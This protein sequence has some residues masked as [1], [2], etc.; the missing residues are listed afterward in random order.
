MAAGAVDWL[1]QEMTINTWV[2][3]IDRMG[4]TTTAGELVQHIAMLN[5]LQ[6]QND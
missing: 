1:I 4:H 5:D 3:A 6:F 2:V